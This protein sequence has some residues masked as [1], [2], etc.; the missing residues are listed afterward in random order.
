MTA[1][2]GQKRRISKALYNELRN[3]A[4]KIDHDMLRLEYITIKCPCACI[5]VCLIL[6]GASYSERVGRR[7]KDCRTSSSRENELNVCMYYGFRLVAYYISFCSTLP[8]RPCNS[9][10]TI[11]PL[12]SFDQ[13]LSCEQYA[14]GVPKCM[15]VVENATKYMDGW[16]KLFVGSASFQH[17][18][19]GV[20]NTEVTSIYTHL[21]SPQEV[22]TSTS[23]TITT[24][25]GIN[26]YTIRS[27]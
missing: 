21:I 24:P 15:F 27:T 7:A 20:A 18:V 5:Y 6:G 23:Y 10:I 4:V 13:Y 2:S 22:C 16:E 25:P 8:R 11:T 14:V 3:N 19:L 1:Q 9:T 17:V 26:C 12:D